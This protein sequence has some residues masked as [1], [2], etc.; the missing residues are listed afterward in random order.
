V[1]VGVA[2]AWW[3]FGQPLPATIAAKRA[4]AAWSSANWPSGWRFWVAG[5]EFLA[6]FYDGPLLPALLAGGL[7]GQVPL[8]RRAP[9]AVQVVSLYG[10][11]VSAA[12]PLLGVPFYTWYAVPGLVA[13]LY[14]TAYALGAAVR[15]MS[16]RQTLG[17]DL[18]AARRVA[19][20]AVA[21]VLAAALASPLR[22]SCELVS[23]SR[24]AM[25]YHLYRE[26]G[27]WLAAH[28]RSDERFAGAEVG[29]LGYFSRRSV[30]DLM[31]LVSPEVV[32]RIRRGDLASSFLLHPTPL[33]VESSYFGL[34]AIAEQPW[35][36]R[37]YELA[38]RFGDD[39]SW[40]RVYRLK[41]GE[42]LP[43]RRRA[44]TPPTERRR[45]AG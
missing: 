24:A 40:V 39:R 4:Q 5:Y 15:G 36:G 27:E 2:A 21:L 33:V 28:S 37:K 31:G 18:P 30:T 26:A 32:G 17:P 13:V 43:R 38:A 25:R 42:E 3:W 35:F 10:L 6:S 1:L 12:Y 34:S 19:A 14:G 22:R 41:P 8:F 45:H 29:T 9:L 23:H 44:W 11:G 16:A 20:A 7:V